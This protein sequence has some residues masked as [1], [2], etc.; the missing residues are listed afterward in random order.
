MNTRNHIGNEM[1]RHQLGISPEE[2]DKATERYLVEL[3]ARHTKVP[4]ADLRVTAPF[5]RFGVQSIMML[6]MTQELERDLGPLPK[7]LFFE[8]SNVKELAA[9]LV[10]AREKALRK[11]LGL[12]PQ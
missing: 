6:Q 7:T 1:N 5:E 12:E 3:L 8:H 4:E 2:L 9:H 11:H 10:V